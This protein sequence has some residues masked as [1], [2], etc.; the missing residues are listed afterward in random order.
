MLL[1]MYSRLNSLRELDNPGGSAEFK[2]NRDSTISL[3]A[4]PLPP[5]PQQSFES[6][7]TSSPFNPA[8]P[9][10]SPI[11]TGLF[12]TNSVDTLLGKKNHIP[13]PN[14]PVSEKVLSY[15]VD[16]VQKVLDD[17]KGEEKGEISDS[18]SEVLGNITPFIPQKLHVQSR[19][20]MSIPNMNTTFEELFAPKE[21]TLPGDKFKA[22]SKK[23][24]PYRSSANKGKLIDTS[25]LS[26]SFI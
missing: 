15:S 7:G 6:I 1:G 2:N 26:R 22:Y 12:S 9:K 8:Q 17:K 25:I 4:T 23:F 13:Y 16:P 24:N 5:Q 21:N 14:S 19:G 10:M 18:L 11:S 20:N 3:Q